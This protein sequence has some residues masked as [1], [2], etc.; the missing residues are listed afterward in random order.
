[1]LRRRTDDLSESLE[2]QTA[3]SEVLQVIS[4]SPGE[5][6]PV[7][8]A[9]LANA[10]KLCAAS[11]GG[12]FLSEDDSFRT[13]ALHGDLSTVFKSQWQDGTL[14]KP[15]PNIPLARAFQSGKPVHV[16]NLREDK[17]YLSGDPLAVGAVDVA[18][19]RTML[20]IPMLKE[21]AAIGIIA[22]YRTEV[23]PFTDKQIEL[24]TNF[25]AQAVIAIE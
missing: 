8:E 3:T 16:A 13:A 18:G 1:E 12:M 5:L 10:T 7:F 24:V 21:S 6:K 17:A 25:A 22:I 20:A 14:F 19:I 15:H 9:M 2:Q 23:S 4:S 11:Y